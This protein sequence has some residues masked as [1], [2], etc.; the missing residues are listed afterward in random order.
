MPASRSLFTALAF[1]VSACATNYIP[2]SG[3]R[4]EGDSEFYEGWFGGQLAAMR[5]PSLKSPEALQQKRRIY[6][7]TVLPTF[8]AGFAI[9]VEEDMAGSVAMHWV[10]LSGAGGYDPGTIFRSGGRTLTP[11]EWTTLS[12][13]IERARLVST[14]REQTFEETI[15]ENGDPI[16]TICVDGT[17]YL[18]E[19]LTADESTFVK[20]SC[21]PDEK[22][23]QQ[24][25]AATLPLAPADV[26]K[27]R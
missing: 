27:R 3:W 24:L 19:Q 14:P 21:V 17:T 13:A 18:F 5:E 12:Q 22:E 11:G 23:L 16:V 15:D 4:D 7:L 9:R 20:R 10:L 1:A 6:R 2:D 26:M 25:I 8:T